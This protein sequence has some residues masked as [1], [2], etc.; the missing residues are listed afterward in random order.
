MKIKELF[1]L[2]G[3]PVVIA[4]L[5]CLSPVILVSLGLASVSFG[6]PLTDIFYREY[7]WYFR[8]V[9]LL[10][11]IL[12]IVWYLR[13]QKGICSIDDVVKRRNEVINIIALAIVVGVAGY[14][15]FLYVIVH[16]IGAFMGLWSYSY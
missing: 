14:F 1:R 15:F 8:L 3:I 6:A 16:Y 11:L 2:S 13:R 4:S 7:K 12:S 10:S 9:G 5:C